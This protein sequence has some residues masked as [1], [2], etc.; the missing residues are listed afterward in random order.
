MDKISA[1]AL[2]G[3]QQ[4]GPSEEEQAKRAADEAQLRRD[5]LATILDVGARE[6]C[7]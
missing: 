7:V 6:R 3:G 1:E 2:Q 5:M 4:G